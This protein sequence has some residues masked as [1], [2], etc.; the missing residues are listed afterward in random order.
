MQLFYRKYGYGKGAPIVALHGLYASSDSWMSIASKFGKQHQ[1]ILV[2]LRNHGRSPHSPQHSYPLMSNDLLE[3]LDKLAINRAIL[4]GHSMGGKTAMHFA[5]NQ[6]NRVKGLVVED[7]SPLRLMLDNENALFHQKIIN[8][9]KSLPIGSFTTRKEA[10]ACLLQKL[11]DMALCQF[12]LKNL[13][14]NKNGKLDWRINLSAIENN[15]PLIMESV[16]TEYASPLNI[17]TLFIKGSESTYVAHKDEE[18]IKQL[19]LKASISTV[20]GADH[21][22]HSKRERDFL[23]CVNQYFS[24][25]NST[26]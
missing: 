23:E 18:A 14:R 9:L 8:A 24:L 7:I 21:W 3:L 6:P 4:M 19:F 16:T 22:V 11:P 13:H 15:L 25:L 17:P 20:H 10:Q 12:L 26:D 1:L 2:D 5:L